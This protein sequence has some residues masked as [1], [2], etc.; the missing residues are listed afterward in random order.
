M[1]KLGSCRR[2]LEQRLWFLLDCI[3]LIVFIWAVLGLCA[4]QAFP[5]LQH[6]GAPLLMAGGLGSCGARAYLLRIQDLPR[7]GIEPVSPALAGRFSTSDPPGKPCWSIF[8]VKL[9][10]FSREFEIQFAT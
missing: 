10:V 9:I 2:S 6:A 7:P 3:F 5:W 1:G 8:E 4:A